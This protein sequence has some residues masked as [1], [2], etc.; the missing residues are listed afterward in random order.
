MGLD[1]LKPPALG[2]FAGVDPTLHSGKETGK[3]RGGWW[4]K[5]PVP[6]F[7]RSSEPPISLAYPFV[8]AGLA[9]RELMIRVI[10]A[11]AAFGIFPPVVLFTDGQ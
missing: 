1:L 11:S 4:V 2:D 5:S 6:T 10:F 8:S 3:V 7:A 9:R